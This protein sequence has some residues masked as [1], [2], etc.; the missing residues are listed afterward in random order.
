MAELIHEEKVEFY[1]NKI[2]ILRETVSNQ[3]SLKISP[4]FLWLF[5]VKLVNKMNQ[6][7]ASMLHFLWGMQQL[8]WPSRI[9]LT[10]PAWQVSK[11]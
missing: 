6:R 10:L 11:E 8:N 1:Y 9:C 3:K 5:H 7:L 2:S 4:A